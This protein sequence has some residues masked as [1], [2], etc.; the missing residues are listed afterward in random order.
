MKAQYKDYFPYFG[1]WP[2]VYSP[3]YILYIRLVCHEEYCSGDVNINRCA[4]NK[5]L[6]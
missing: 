1:H 4:A 5:E 3:L 2:E 6:S